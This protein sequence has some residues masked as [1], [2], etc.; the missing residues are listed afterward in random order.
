MWKFMAELNETGT[1]IILTTHYLEEAEKMCRNVAIIDRGEII[2]NT[3]IKHLLSTLESETYI[4]LTTGEIKQFKPVEGYELKRLDSFALR[5]ELL[6]DQNIGDVIRLLNGQGIEVKSV[7]S[8][9][10]K[11]EELFLNL[12]NK[13]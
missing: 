6:R 7:R 8:K 1:T 3:S 2:E 12:V 5:L 11:L 10:N 13:N 9:S 4:L